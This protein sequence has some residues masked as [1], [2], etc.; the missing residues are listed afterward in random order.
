MANIFL[1]GGTGFVGRHLKESLLNDR[2]QLYCLT[3]QRFTEIDGNGSVHWIEADIADGGNDFDILAEMDYVIHLAGLI[4]ARTT[5]E[6]TRTNVDGTRALLEACREYNPRLKRFV[7]M[8]SIAAMGPRLEDELLTETMPNLPQSA[9][10]ASKLEAERIAGEYGAHLPIV[11][12][13]PSFVYGGGDTRTLHYLNAILNSTAQSWR[14]NIRT[15][16]FC[17]ISDVVRVCRLA[18]EHPVQSGETCIIS[19]PEIYTWE[20]L[21]VLLHDTI[22]Q[23]ASRAMITERQ[24]EELT[25]RVSRLAFIVPDLP[26][27]HYW[28]C[29]TSR[30]SEKLG[31]RAECSLAEGSLDTI[32]WYLRHGMLALEE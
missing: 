23:F 3:R 27:Y 32:L 8:S 7:Y 10:G 18:M 5:A 29:D 28:G 13:R 22:D 4:S 31:F 9:Y 25:G 15:L 2:H 17:H 30:A 16:S 24:R 12:L 11:I 6:Y 21:R 14:T 26:Q 19:S 1:T 20:Q